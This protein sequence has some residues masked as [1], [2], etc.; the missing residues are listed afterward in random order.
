MS[1]ILDA[2]RKADAER[3]RDPAR[4]IH[5][6]PVVPLAQPPRAAWQRGP[7]IAVGLALLALAAAVATWRSTPAPGVPAVA[8]AP[9]GRV[10][11]PPAV[12][13]APA[14]VLLPPPRPVPVSAVE[15]VAK[16]APK[17]MA[18]AQIAA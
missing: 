7:L 17:L 10:P 1:Y 15:P 14:A 3:E 12:T 11:L 13:A 5:A 4:G 18:K 6:Q 9:V 16:A 8:A 2:L